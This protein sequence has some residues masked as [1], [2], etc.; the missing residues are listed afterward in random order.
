MKRATAFLNGL[1][2]NTTKELTFKYT[3]EE[4]AHKYI[5]SKF[6]LCK[7]ETEKKEKYTYYDYPELDK[8]VHDTG[9]WD[10][11]TIYGVKAGSNGINDSIIVCEFLVCDNAHI[12][13][14][15]HCM[16]TVWK[17]GRWSVTVECEAPELA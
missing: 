16:V 14:S 1:L 17:N 11:Y 2:G 6:I 3:G 15:E 4:E 13:E 12:M 8:E 7:T 9:Y 5:I 10:T